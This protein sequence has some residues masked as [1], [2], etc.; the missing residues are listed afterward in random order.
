MND[1][2]EIGFQAAAHI[3]Q[4]NGVQG[5]GPIT[6]TGPSPCDEL[7]SASPL[8]FMIEALADELA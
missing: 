4:W 2:A 5:E 7:A 1:L 8:F 3:M 6:M